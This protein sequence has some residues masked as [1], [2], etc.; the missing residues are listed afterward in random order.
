MSNGA[1]I[2][3]ED[4]KKFIQEYIAVNGETIKRAFWYDKNLIQ[5]VLNDNQNCDGIR[6]YMGINDS[7]EQCVVIVGV[8]TNGHDLTD[9][10]ILDYGAPCPNQCDPNSYFNS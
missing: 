4:A 7:G 1:L 6:I 2:S 10:K 3:K 8:D 9:S 5:D